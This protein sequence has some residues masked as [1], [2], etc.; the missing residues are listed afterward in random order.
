MV[1]LVHLLQA[2]TM[3]GF[4]SFFA[5]KG[6]EDSEW[7]EPWSADPGRAL[8]SPGGQ[9]CP[10]VHEMTVPMLGFLGARNHLP[11]I[12]AFCPTWAHRVVR[13]VKAWNLPSG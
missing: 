1:L 13:V 9:G 12:P 10:G 5:K 2:S 11:P 6:Q 7:G 3:K 4:C 8:G